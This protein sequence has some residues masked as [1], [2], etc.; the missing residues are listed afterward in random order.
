MSQDAEKRQTTSILWGQ[1]FG[2]E[3]SISDELL[4]RGADEL[5]NGR[6]D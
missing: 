1:S 3:S 5:E 2:G 6:V 4:E